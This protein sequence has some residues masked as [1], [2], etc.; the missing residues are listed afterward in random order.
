MPLG[1][2]Y[3][4][5]AVTLTWYVIQIAIVLDGLSKKQ[6]KTIQFL[7]QYRVQGEDLL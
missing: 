7:C 5:Y 4:L 2:F 3:E 1:S 6:N